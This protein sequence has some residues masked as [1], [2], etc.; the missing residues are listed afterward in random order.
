MNSKYTYDPRYTDGVEQ[1]LAAATDQYP[2]LSTFRFDLRFPTDGTGRR[3]ERVIS[4]FFDSLKYHAN[5]QMTT[6]RHAGLTC[7]NLTSIRYI[8][9]TEYGL[10]DGNRHYHVMLLVNKDTFH[11]LGDYQP[12]CNDGIDSLANVIQKAWCSAL[13]LP[14][15]AYAGLV[16]FPEQ[17]CGWIERKR[18]EHED[19]Y[20]TARQR[21]MYLAKE[22][23]KHYGDGRSFGC[24]QRNPSVIGSS[25]I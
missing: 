9:C 4:R 13:K 1:T 21:A 18:P 24:S 15:E 14:W 10:V 5:A 19:Q 3:D 25:H 20:A 7:K 17:P 2:R 11:T 8:W 12:Q 16:H 6:R 23:T 22:Y